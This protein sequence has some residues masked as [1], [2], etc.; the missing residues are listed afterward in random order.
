MWKSGRSGLTHA[1]NARVPSAP[2]SGSLNRAASSAR[3]SLPPWTVGGGPDRDFDDVERRVHHALLTDPGLLARFR[4]AF[5]G[6][7][8]AS[9]DEMVRLLGWVWDCPDDGTANVLGYRCGGCGR[10]K[11]SALRWRRL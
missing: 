6:R 3:P 9:Y 10:T 5:P 8:T 1:V 4:R 11:R 7:E 2:M